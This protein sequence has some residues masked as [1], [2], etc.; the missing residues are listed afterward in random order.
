MALLSLSRFRINRI[1]LSASTGL[2]FLNLFMVRTRPKHLKILAKGR[3]IK[4]KVIKSVSISLLQT[5][6]SA[7]SVFKVLLHLGRANPS[8]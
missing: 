3:A 6:Q 7:P 2:Q 5:K 1:M 4:K 8:F